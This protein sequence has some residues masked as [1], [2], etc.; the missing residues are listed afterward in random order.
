MVQ[1]VSNHI[2]GYIFF[3]V[4]GVLGIAMLAI[5]IL[6]GAVTGFWVA[7]VGIF[8]AGGVFVL[9]GFLL[10]ALGGKSICTLD[11]QQGTLEIERHPF[12][13]YQCCQNVKKERYPLQEIVDVLWLTSYG[14]H[15]ATFRIAFQHVSGKVIN[16]TNY[17]SNTLR[18]Q[19]YQNMKL[20]HQT[21][22]RTHAP[23]LLQQQVTVSF[24]QTAVGTGPTVMPMSYQ[25]GMVP[26]APMPTQPAMMQPAMVQPAM[27]Q[28]AMVQPGAMPPQPAPQQ[29]FM[30]M[31]MPMPMA[32]FASNPA[33]SGLKTEVAPGM[34]P[35]PGNPQYVAPQYVPQYQPPSL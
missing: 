11:E 14:K 9:M 2:F 27:V 32:S 24:G 22:V 28:P 34:A 31:P 26:G 33:A 13:V 12:P 16:M 20:W 15:G 8:A 25:G 4:F 29:Q 30:P 17:S 35:F 21:W 7:Y 23:Q 6:L 5:A 3:F 19:I 10:A 18:P 1:E